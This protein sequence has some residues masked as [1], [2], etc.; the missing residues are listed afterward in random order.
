MDLQPTDSE[1]HLTEEELLGLTAQQEQFIKLYTVPFKEQLLI[2]YNLETSANVQVEIISFDN[3]I[4]LVLDSSAKQSGAKTVHTNP[5]I[6]GGRYII[7]ITVNG[8]VHTRMI[9][10]EN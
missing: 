7:K 8:K 4:R 3:S 6:E 1:T 9:V 5:D 2:Q 10:K